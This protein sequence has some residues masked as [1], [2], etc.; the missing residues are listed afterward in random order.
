MHARLRAQPKERRWYDE[1]P[2]AW[3]RSVEAVES[4]CSAVTVVQASF[5]AGA[6][7]RA[8]QRDRR[9]VVAVQAMWRG[10]RE[11]EVCLFV[12]F[13]VPFVAFISNSGDVSVPWLQGRNS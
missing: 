1:L 13:S 4:A 9:A 6:T 3:A 5:R 7:R 11:R 12:A 2:G 8:F 10:G